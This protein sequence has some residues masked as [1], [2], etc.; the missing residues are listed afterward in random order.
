[1]MQWI[2]EQEY[3]M[4]KKFNVSKLISKDLKK[5]LKKHKVWKQFKYNFKN[6]QTSVYGIYDLLNSFDWSSTPEGYSY[7]DNLHDKYN[8]TKG[9]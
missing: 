3:V 7:W 4:G 8:K 2:T 5:F 6:Y 1:M 9:M